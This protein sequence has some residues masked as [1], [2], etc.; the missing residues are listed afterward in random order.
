MEV[1]RETELLAGLH[2]IVMMHKIYREHSGDIYI[3][4]ACQVTVCAE[5]TS[6]LDWKDN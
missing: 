3:W 2:A 1:E 5:E 4:I 6:G